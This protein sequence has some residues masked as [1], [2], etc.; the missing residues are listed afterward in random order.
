VFLASRPRGVYRHCDV[1]SSPR[2]NKRGKK[3]EASSSTLQRHLSDFRTTRF[4][5][6]ALF[7]SQPAPFSASHQALDPPQPPTDFQYS[8]TPSRISRT[9]PST[10]TMSPSVVP[11][12][13]RPQG[14]VICL[15]DVDGTLT[16]ARRVR[17]LTQSARERVDEGGGS[18]EPRCSPMSASRERMEQRK[19]TRSS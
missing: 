12:A 15:F 8:H 2:S 9:R 7:P 10:S 1:V 13:S 11:F 16:P 17:T 18:D 5:L 3:I 6:L 19:R 4:F 14:D